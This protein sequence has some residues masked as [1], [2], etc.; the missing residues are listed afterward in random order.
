M[1]V[2]AGKRERPTGW[3]ERL[4]CQQECWRQERQTRVCAPLPRKEDEAEPGQPNRWWP[5]RGP[6][7]DADPDGRRY[8]FASR[9]G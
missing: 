2:E 4:L 8:R 1:G 9:A 6:G 5:L 3:V 7:T